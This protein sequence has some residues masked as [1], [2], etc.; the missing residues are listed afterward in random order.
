MNAE[1]C[2]L[3]NALKDRAGR[4]KGMV[5]RDL[6]VQHGNYRRAAERQPDPQ[7]AGHKPVPPPGFIGVGTLKG[8]QRQRRARTPITVADRSS[9]TL[10]TT[11][12]LQSFA[13][14]WS[15]CTSESRSFSA[16]LLG[17]EP[18]LDRRSCNC[19]NPHPHHPRVRSHRELPAMAAGHQAKEGGELSPRT[20]LGSTL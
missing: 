4:K 9:M 8:Q 13:L 14:S 17:G 3:F 6:G 7:Q 12:P 10:G 2:R 16:T 11:C 18:L 15:L 5:W 1:H 19:S 20:V